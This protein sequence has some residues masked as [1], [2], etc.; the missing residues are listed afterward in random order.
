MD[1]LINY[2]DR[3]HIKILD[4]CNKY[5]KSS[6]QN[7]FDNNSWKCKGKHGRNHFIKLKLNSKHSLTK[8]KLKFK[9][10]KIYYYNVSI[11][12]S[13]KE[14]KGFVDLIDKQ[15]IGVDTYFSSLKY[16]KFRAVGEKNINIPLIRLKIK[17]LFIYF[18]TLFQK[19][20]DRHF[21]E[22]DKKKLRLE[23]LEIY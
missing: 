1:K 11:A 22:V 20:G 3:K 5:E 12:G 21:E 4:Y 6:P 18:G 10:S 17:Y 23:K 8:L 14:Y 9:M 19:K 7:L 2:F 15:K 13:L 16:Y